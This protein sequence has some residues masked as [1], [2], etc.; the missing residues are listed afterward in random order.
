MHPQDPA[1]SA[2]DAAVVI[3]RHIADRAQQYSAAWQPVFAAVGVDVAS[4][5]LV[6]N[7]LVSA[8]I[9]VGTQAAAEAEAA[10][11]LAEVHVVAESLLFA[12][13]YAV[14]TESLLFATMYAFAAALSRSVQTGAQGGG[15]AAAAA[16]A[17]T[18]A[19]SPAAAGSVGSSS[20]V[21][22]GQLP[23]LEPPEE[24]AEADAAE[25]DAL[26]VAFVH[27]V[28]HGLQA[29]SAASSQPGA[30]AAAAAAV[31]AGDI[32]PAAGGLA[33]AGGIA[34]G[35]VE[36]QQQGPGVSGAVASQQ[37]RSTNNIIQWLQWLVVSAEGWHT[38]WHGGNAGYPG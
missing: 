25:A 6:F 32:Q 38:G 12:T 23:W 9:R 22:A 10:D 17:A 27:G 7:S 1:A 24:A 3:Q 14:A 31:T 36:A 28:A 16:A 26:R 18:S 15:S 29:A 30:A 34:S 37:V 20:G 11:M 2:A 21:Q 8:A 13:M 33:V 19:A 35:V 4:S 5:A